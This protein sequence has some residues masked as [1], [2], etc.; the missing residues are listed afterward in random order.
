VHYPTDVEAGRVSATVIAAALTENAKFRKNFKKTKE[1][2]KV[3][4]AQ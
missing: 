2:L 1:E 3:N 4:L